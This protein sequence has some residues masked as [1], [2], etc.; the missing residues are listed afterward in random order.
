MKGLK[1]FINNIQ[2][3]QII[4]FRILVEEEKDVQTGGGSKASNKD[5]MQNLIT[6][7]IASIN[8]NTLELKSWTK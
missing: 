8:M 1:I 7:G 6:L 4:S 3:D 2:K 5:L